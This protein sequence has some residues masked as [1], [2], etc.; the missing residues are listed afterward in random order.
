MNQETR[1]NKISGVVLTIGIS[2]FVILFIGGFFLALTGVITTGQY[3]G[4]VA[5]YI[6]SLNVVGVII[7]LI[8]DD[9]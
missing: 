1:I 4:Y 8:N 6:V 3:L 9:L 5:I 7:A 2:G